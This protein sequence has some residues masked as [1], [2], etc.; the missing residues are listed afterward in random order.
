MKNS[1]PNALERV[2][3]LNKIL[4]Q[5]RNPRALFYKVVNNPKL[6]ALKNC[7]VVN[8]LEQKN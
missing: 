2:A 6:L 8:N 5:S 1:K 7:A 4:K 3:N